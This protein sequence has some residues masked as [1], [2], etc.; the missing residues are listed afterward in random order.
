MKPQFR[1]WHLLILMAIVAISITGRK[2]YQARVLEAKLNTQI[3]SLDLS[4][5][6]TN[7]L[8]YGR[9]KTVRQLIEYNEEELFEIRNM[10]ETTLVEI[11]EKLQSLGLSLKSP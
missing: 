3:E 7:C 8:L 1:I 9:V 5:R 11:R 4:L 2:V 6:A 10:G